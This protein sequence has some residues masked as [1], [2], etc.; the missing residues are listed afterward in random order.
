LKALALK[1]E[2][3]EGP[4]CTD[5]RGGYLA[6]EAILNFRWIPADERSLLSSKPIDLKGKVYSQM[7]G[8]FFCPTSVIGPTGRFHNEVEKEIGRNATLA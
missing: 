1:G 7:Q 3:G 5:H 6:P 4:F 2:R 8:M